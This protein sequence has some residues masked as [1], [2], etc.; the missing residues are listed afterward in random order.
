MTIPEYQNYGHY[1][2]EGWAKEPKETF[3][4]LARILEA[5]ITPTT[6]LDVGCATG[7]LIAFIRSRFPAVRSSGWDVFDPLLETGRK[8]L[9]DVEFSNISVVGSD[10]PTRR[11]DLVTAIGVMS[12]FDHETLHTFW[13]NLISVT[14]DDGLLLVLSPLNEF[15]CDI[16][17]SHRKR[18]GGQPGKWERG[19]SIYSFETVRELVGG[20]GWNLTFEP[21]QIGMDLKPS[22]DPVR[23]WTMQTDR[24]PRQLTN[25]LKLLINH[26]FMIARKN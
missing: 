19:W 24:N 10:L 13:R 26:Y 4:A 12:I 16:D 20:L 6:H 21:F 25:G 23:T 8:L 1:I 9:P 14:A 2:R 18:T 17:L 5:R 3:K 22:A 11:F 15:G 7:E